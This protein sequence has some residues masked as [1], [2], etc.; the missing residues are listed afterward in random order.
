MCTYTHIQIYAP[1]PCDARRS[2]S[3]GMVGQT[4]AYGNRGV[5][6]FATVSCSMSSVHRRAVGP[7][8]GFNCFRTECQWPSGNRNTRSH[9]LNNDWETGHRGALCASRCY[10]HVCMCLS[11]TA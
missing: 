2:M 3:S 8:L 9:P 1:Q 10:V 7:E 6:C 5:S 4:L 11:D